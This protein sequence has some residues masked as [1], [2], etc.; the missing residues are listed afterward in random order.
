MEDNDLVAN[1]FSMALERAGDCS[2]IISE[3]VP[4]ILKHV[5]TGEID[6]VLL[7]VSLNNSEWEGRPIGGVELCRMLKDESPRRLPAT[8]HAMSGDRERLAES[9]S[10][11]G[12]LEKPVY[13]S[14]LL[15]EKV[16]SLIEPA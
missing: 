8:A 4:T 2:C 6:L 11:D 9:S 14:A 10:A 7:D 13:E 1:F 15:V 12:Y 3:D 16:R 5:S